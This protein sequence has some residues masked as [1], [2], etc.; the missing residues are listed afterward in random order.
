MG[1]F[2][3]VISAER[4]LL[5]HFNFKKFHPTYNFFERFSCLEESHTIH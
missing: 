5:L 4:Q 3:L 1:S 2:L